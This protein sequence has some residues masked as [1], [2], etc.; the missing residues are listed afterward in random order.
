MNKADPPL[1]GALD[2]GATLPVLAGPD[3]S[4]YRA[5][6]QIAGQGGRGHA[7]AR[8]PPRPPNRPW[9]LPAPA[10]DPAASTMVR[11]PWTTPHLNQLRSSAPR[12]R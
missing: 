12:R 4:G 8:C 5:R 1:A 11:V 10:L 9:R 6:P 2:A 3:F 7:H